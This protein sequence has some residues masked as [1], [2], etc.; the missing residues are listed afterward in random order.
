MGPSGVIGVIGEFN[1]FHDGHRFLLRSAREATGDRPVVS[2][3]SGNFLQRGDPALFDKWKRATAAVASGQVD[4]VLELP[5]VYAVSSAG[6]FARAGL[7]VLEGLGMVEILAF[8]SESGD[9]AKLRRTAT[10]LRIVDREYG[11]ELKAR[12]KEGHSYPASR[13]WLLEKK[14]PQV[15][16]AMPTFPNNILALEYLSCWQD[17]EAFTVQRK[18]EYHMS[19]SAIRA[20]YEKAH[21]A[22]SRQKEDRFFTLIRSSILA[23]SVSEL[24]KIASA[25]EGLGYKMYSEVRLAESRDQF[26]QALKSK[27]YTYS[28]INR[29]LCQTLLGI[30]K[31]S[32]ETS[33]PYLRVLAMNKT[34]AAL[35]RWAKKHDRITLPIVDSVAEAMKR[36][37]GIR[38]T[39]AIDIRASDMFNLLEARNLYRFSDYVRKPVL[40]L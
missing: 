31:E 8:G 28:R 1:P 19:A 20:A 23:K 7:S 29:M 6:Y 30:D 27:R 9:L 10:L 22:L 37:G 14:F 11:E 3:M 26:V 33:K 34:G 13:Q 32:L 40:L 18:D 2:V 38:S 5:T 17:R 36:E 25:G 39:L 15:D 4:L 21:P 16:K 35:L 12:M 24:E